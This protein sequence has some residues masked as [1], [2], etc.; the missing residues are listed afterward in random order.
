MATGCTNAFSYLITT[1]IITYMERRTMAA[2]PMLTTEQW[3][4]IF[5]TPDEEATIRNA[6]AISSACNTSTYVSATLWP[7]DRQS[8]FPLSR[9]VSF[10]LHVK[11]AQGTIVAPDRARKTGFHE[12]DEPELARA[13][14]RLRRNVQRRY[15]AEQIVKRTIA[16][17]K[18]DA[19]LAQ[20]WAPILQM[21]TTSWGGRGGRA[22]MALAKAERF[23]SSMP[24]TK[25]V[26]LS[27]AHKRYVAWVV[28]QVLAASLLPPELEPNI[29]T[30]E[31]S[32]YSGPHLRYL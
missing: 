7:G 21:I 26:Q 29:P 3:Q 12:A 10:T 25:P 31:C 27:K 18:N 6:V 22:G 5:A 17:C 23:Q 16:M 20:L 1:T 14:Y 2:Q 28:Q 8:T 30:V 15:S 19:Q 4:R 13:I 24:K 32:V 9:A 11:K